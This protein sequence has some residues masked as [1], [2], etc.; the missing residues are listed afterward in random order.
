MRID[1]EM[2]TITTADFERV[3]ETIPL[4]E[5]ATRAHGRSARALRGA[6]GAVPGLARA[7]TRSQ[8]IEARLADV[9]FEGLKRVNPEYL[10]TTIA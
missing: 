8:D 5:A 1:V 6:G 10:A 7:V 2:G 3:P 4:G 9:R